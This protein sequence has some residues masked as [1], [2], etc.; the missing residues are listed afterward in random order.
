MKAT[1]S[2]RLNPAY[3]YTTALQDN[4][5][6]FFLKNTT[7][8]NTKKTLMRY[9]KI[10]A[11]STQHDS[12]VNKVVFLSALLFIATCT[13]G[14]LLYASRNPSTP[15]RNE[16]PLKKAPPGIKNHP[17]RK[18]NITATTGY[19]TG[20]NFKKRREI[21][22]TPHT[23]PTPILLNN[24]TQVKTCAI[25]NGTFTYD[26]INKPLIVQDV[27]HLDLP[28]LSSAVSLFLQ[29]CQVNIL[30]INTI[31]AQPGHLFWNKLQLIF[32]FMPR[33]SLRE[34]LVN[35]KAQIQAAKEKINN[36]DIQFIR[37]DNDG[38][39]GS[40]IGGMLRKST[41]QL[42]VDTLVYTTDFALL[43]DP[44]AAVNTIYHEMKHATSDMADSAYYPYPAT[45]LFQVERFAEEI[46]TIFSDKDKFLARFSNPIYDIYANAT[47][48]DQAT[49]N[50]IEV[51]FYVKRTYPRDVAARKAQLS[52]ER[53]TMN[54]EDYAK[55]L[56]A[57]IFSNSGSINYNE[58]L[59]FIGNTS[60]NDIF[61]GLLEYVRHIANQGTGYLAQ[62]VTTQRPGFIEQLRR[63]T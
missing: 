46:N 25:N 4:E 14:A 63:A 19:P 45:F 15:L 49:V 27:N 34:L 17:A 42:S 23:A 20:P 35:C 48:K 62:G 52:A 50:S 51:K 32:P 6:K 57:R 29:R 8:K 41:Y 13:G 11:I 9:E 16:P 61:Y 18:V 33:S 26:T 2:F 59:L 53:K 38:S 7:V 5:R 36:H 56:Q 30:F 12:Q 1:N 58:A 55:I 31:I 10:K 22:V 21:N 37:C 60:I 3:Q 24:A 39:L 47:T 40:Y 28:S 54:M 44:Y 43:T